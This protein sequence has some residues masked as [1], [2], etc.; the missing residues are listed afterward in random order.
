M[1][2]RALFQLCYIFFTLGFDLLTGKNR[3]DII[4]LNSGQAY[5]IL[6]LKQDV[7]GYQSRERRNLDLRKQPIPK[8]YEEDLR[9]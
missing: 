4:N 2:K 6:A 1:Y 9:V 3:G 8:N 5:A 7:S